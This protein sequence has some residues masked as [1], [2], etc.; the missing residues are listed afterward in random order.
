MLTLTANESCWQGRPFVDQ[1][2]IAGNRPIREQWLDLSVGRADIAEVPPQELRL[3]QQKHLSVVVSPPV[4]L[5]ALE[6]SDTRARSGT[7]CCAR[8]FQKVSTAVRS[9]M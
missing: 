6:V 1:I 5:L 4:E 7:S 2:T 3:A 9:R 8:R